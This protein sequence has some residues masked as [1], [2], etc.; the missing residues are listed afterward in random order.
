MKPN[1]YTVFCFIFFFLVQCSIFPAS[2][3]VLKLAHPGITNDD[4]ELV[5]YDGAGHEIGILN[6]TA[7][8]DLGNSSNGDIYLYMQ[9]HRVNPFTNPW[10]IMDWFVNG[11]WM[12]TV[13]VGFVIAA[14]VA[15]ITFAYSRGKQK[16][17]K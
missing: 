5:I 4:T 11:G 6:S 1:K 8:L 14:I 2:A 15:L 12:P 3:Q 16:A 9:Q 10:W 13:L 7:P 17:W